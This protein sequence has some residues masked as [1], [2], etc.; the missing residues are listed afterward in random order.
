MKGYRKESIDASTN[1]PYTRSHFN[2]VDV[3]ACLLVGWLVGFFLLLSF[4]AEGE[5]QYPLILLFSFVYFFLCAL[6]HTH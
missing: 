1:L 4:L 6:I 3:V 2:A 5:I